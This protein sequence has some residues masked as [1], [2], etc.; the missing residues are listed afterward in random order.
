MIQQRHTSKSI[1]TVIHMSEFH[2]AAARVTMAQICRA[3]GLERS[4]PSVLDA[5]TDILIQ[6]L[7]M[8]GSKARGAAEARGD[9]DCSVD[10]AMLAAVE[11]DA[12]HG[13]LQSTGLRHGREA[14]YTGIEDIM[15]LLNWLRGPLNARIAVLTRP[16]RQPSATIGAAQGAA[17]AA[18]PSSA[19][20]AA[21][22]Q[23]QPK[24]AGQIQM[25]E[26]SNVH[27]V[28][29]APNQPDITNT[30]N[31]QPGQNVPDSGHED[32]QTDWLTM[33]LNRHILMGHSSMFIDTELGPRRDPDPTIYS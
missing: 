9:S 18:L 5:L 30:Q 31:P 32:A 24:T 1:T 16:P 12:V 27:Q 17:L 26:S 11:C 6:Y 15:E 29:Y 25:E 33:A 4:V 10:D 23:S 20:T 22:S 8:I 19:A 21:A 3:C 13:G 2:F 7:M 14:Y 28:S